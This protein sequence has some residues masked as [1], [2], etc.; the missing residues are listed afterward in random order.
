MYGYLSH[1]Q[2]Q[3]VSIQSGILQQFIITFEKRAKLCDEEEK[4]LFF[5]STKK[6]Y[7][8]NDSKIRSSKKKKSRDDEKR[9]KIFNVFIND[10]LRQSASRKYLRNFFCA[11]QISHH[12]YEIVREAQIF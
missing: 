1:T 4:M 10:L 9:K 2:S 8:E 3:L 6:N 11:I 7:S 5:R 12:I